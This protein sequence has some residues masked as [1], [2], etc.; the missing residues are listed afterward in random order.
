[1][2]TY[3]YVCGKCGEQ[4]TRYLSLKEFETEKVTCSKCNSPDVKQQIGNVMIRT[5]RKS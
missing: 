1:M 2:P 3:D 4:F 5:S